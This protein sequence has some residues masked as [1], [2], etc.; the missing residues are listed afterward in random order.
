MATASF[1]PGRSRG[2]RILVV[3]GAA[4]AAGMV[5]MATLVAALAG[6]IHLPAP[7]TGPGPSSVSGVPA[8][9]LRIDEAA[10]ATCPG[11]SWSV[12]AAIGKV[13][14]GFGANTGPSSAGALGP[15]QFE[16]ATFAGY[17]HPVPADQ[18]P[19]PAGSPNP[20][21]IQNP[22][23]AIYAAARYLC[24]NGAATNI[25]GAIYAYNH[26]SW[27]VSEVLAQAQ[28]FQAHAPAAPASSGGGNAAPSPQ[29]ATALTFARTAIG[30]PYVWG[31]TGNGGFDCSG[32]TQA[33]WAAAGVSIPRTSEAQWA[34]LPHVTT[35][36]PGD[37]VFFAEPGSF[38]APPNHVGIYLGA[39]QMIDAPYPGVNVRV[40]PIDTAH[41]MGYAQP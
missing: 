39:G 31:G 5:G 32:L 24:A 9:Y 6:A 3:L 28:T 41:L 37:L 2:G 16:P 30:T 34:A 8:N 4:G 12:L 18:A 26:A 13:E 23:D 27:Y 20:P 22:T 10:A 1:A 15:M 21:S 17:D 29:A 14:S 40:D 35:P 36:Q 33:A 7:A 38:Q 19:N 11:L 25:N